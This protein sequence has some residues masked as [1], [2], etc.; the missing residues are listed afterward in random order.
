MRIGWVSAHPDMPTAYASQTAL[1][2]P[3]LQAAG[4]ELAIFATA[5]QDSYGSVWRGSIPVFPK[6]PYADIG[7][8][9]VRPHHD[10][11]KADLVVT[12]FCTWIVK[13]PQVWRDMRV[14]HLTPVDCDPMSIRD[15][16]VIAETGG[17]PAAVSRHGESMMRKGGP[18]REKL[19]PLYLPHGVDVKTFRPPADRDGLRAGMGYD[20]KF[21]VGMNFMNNDKFRKNIQEAIRGFA[22]FHGKHPDSLLALHAI[23]SLPEGYNLPAYVRHLGIT[24]AVR[25]TPQYELVTG[26]IPPKVLADWYGALDVYLGPGNEGF[27]L[28]GLEAQACGTPAILGDWGPG[29]ELAGDGWLCGG[30]LWWNDIHQADWHHASVASIAACLEEAYEDARNRRQAARDN[31][32]GW[33]INRQIRDHWEPVL[34][35]IG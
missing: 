16:R 4:H 15:Y 34:N 11:W 5:G 23:Q 25:W 27:G 33:D 20:G 13:Y 6:T 18:G 12:F 10:M 7:E 8:D 35:G 29:P 19:D 28:P 22:V 24:D 26:M 17:T 9:V 14:I 30:E 1:I 2:V 32:L 31:A 3:R 21:V